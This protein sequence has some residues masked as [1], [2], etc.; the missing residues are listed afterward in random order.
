MRPNAAGNMEPNPEDTQ[1]FDT[2]LDFK[3]GAS[4]SGTGMCEATIS[5]AC[6]HVETR[7]DHLSRYTAEHIPHFLGDA[8][9]AVRPPVHSAHASDT[10]RTG[11][12]LHLSNSGHV[13]MRFMWDT[14]IF[15]KLPEPP[16]Q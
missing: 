13:P 10:A 12:V 8:S 7:V 3:N 15:R 2:M 1:E 9:D 5:H 4:K 14:E 6:S 11:H 16:K